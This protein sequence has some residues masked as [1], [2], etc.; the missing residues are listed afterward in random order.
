M[1]EQASP[2]PWAFQ[3]WAYETK[4]G[5][6]PRKAVLMVLATMADGSTGRCQARQETLSEYTEMSV[7]AVRNHLRGLEDAKVIA[8]RPQYRRDG[9]RRSDEFLLRAPW[10]TEWPDGEQIKDRPADPA[11]YGQPPADRDVDHRQIATEEV[12][13]SAGQE[14]PL[15]NDHL[16]TTTETARE[17]ADAPTLFETPKVAWEEDPADLAKWRPTYY[18]LMPGSARDPERYTW[19]DPDPADVV[20]DFYRDR[21]WH[22]GD[23]ISPQAKGI[24][25]ALKTYP[26]E[27]ILRAVAGVLRH[28]WSRSVGKDDLP[29][30]LRI[31]ETTGVDNIGKFA[32]LVPEEDLLRELMAAEANRSNYAIWKVEDFENLDA[33][34][35][36]DNR[37]V[38]EKEAP[39]RMARFLV[40]E[41]QRDAA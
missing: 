31:N 5:N 36:F 6:A 26:T 7:R 37:H 35:R 25:S 10:V 15:G 2:D 23:S 30:I 28:E 41:A 34:W 13:R 38:L 27:T 9:S 39:K 32:K 18:A 16:G 1:S 11:A 40:W 12:S 33:R 21:L 4:T 8:R 3:R 29:W 20:F 24:R 14:L 19:R 22:F 17:R